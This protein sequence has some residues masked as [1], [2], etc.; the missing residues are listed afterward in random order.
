MDIKHRVTYGQVKVPGIREPQIFNDGAG[1]AMLMSRIMQ[2]IA[3]APNRYDSDI[4]ITLSFEPIGKTLTSN[5][6]ALREMIA[7]IDPSQIELA[8]DDTSNPWLIN[9]MNPQ[10]SNYDPLYHEYQNCSSPAHRAMKTP[11]D[12]SI[13][14]KHMD[15]HYVGTQWWDGS[16]R[17]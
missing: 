14:R 17:W 3:A 15:I 6:L 8:D 16:H 1:M 2:C 10:S 11:E 7:M 4:V 13:L 12:L 9:P 5:E